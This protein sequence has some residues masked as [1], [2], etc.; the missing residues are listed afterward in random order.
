MVGGRREQACRGH[1]GETPGDLGVWAEIGFLPGCSG[2]G[3]LSGPGM[4]RGLW[5]R[6]SGLGEHRDRVGGGWRR[7][8]TGK[9]ERGPLSM[10]KACMNSR[11]GVASREEGRCQTAS[12]GFHSWADPPSSFPA[13]L[14]WSQFLQH[15]W[16][17]LPDPW[18]DASL[19]NPS[20]CH[21]SH[22]IVVTYLMSHSLEDRRFSE[23]R[24]PSSLT[25]G[26][27]P[28]DSQ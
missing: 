28:V 16:R 4:I 17:A 24:H 13:H 5:K 23:S 12:Q 7:Q 14:F 20:F 27:Y 1:W 15:V 18:V 22:C 6:G 10:R 25:Q 2:A 8:T 9:P 11:D 21:S 26:L 19:V 3:R